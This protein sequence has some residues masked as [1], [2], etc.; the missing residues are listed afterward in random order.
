MNRSKALTDLTFLLLPLV[1]V[2]SLRF[3]GIEYIGVLTM[4]TG[5]LLT[6]LLL[7][8][9]GQSLADIGWRHIFRGK[10]L[11][12]H[13]LNVMA[14]TGI[15]LVA[16][17][18][19]AGLLFGG[20]EQS[21]AVEQL[22]KNVW[23]FLLDVTVLTWVFIAFGEELVFRGMI[24]SRLEV[25]FAVKGRSGIAL[26]SMA[27]GVLFGAGHASQGATGMVMTGVVG[28]AL[29]IYFLTRGQRTLIPLVLS[30]GI[31]DT[32]VL[33]ASWLSRTFAGA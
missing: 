15:C 10:A 1:G 32:T 6:L 17:G 23:L 19:L 16:A 30:H 29:A 2:W 3:Q 31:I 18:V 21:A 20:P 4:A 11:G 7:R 12:I 13:T 8:W 26:V 22:P 27:Q 24:L 14:L 5:I 9:R 28:T 33:S 25:V